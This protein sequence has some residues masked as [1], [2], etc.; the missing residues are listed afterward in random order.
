MMDP[1]PCV[2]YT[3][4]PLS[5]G[6]VCNY[7]SL[8]PSICGTN[9]SGNCDCMWAKDFCTRYDWTEIPIIPLNVLYN[10]SDPANP[11]G[12]NNIVPLPYGQASLGS[13]VTNTNPLIQY[14]LFV[15]PSVVTGCEV[16]RVRTQTWPSGAVPMALSNQ[17]PIWTQYGNWSGLTTNVG[18]FRTLSGFFD[19][20]T[21]SWVCPYDFDNGA[22]YLGGTWF[23]GVINYNAE[24]D[25]RG[26]PAIYA[27][28]VGREVFF[29]FF[30]F[31][32]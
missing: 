6:C 1:I 17:G 25:L 8:D 19:V 21:P 15:P 13:N 2:D 3:C 5:P 20:S 14:R 30:F 24:V 31:F 26:L 27:S 9:V 10:A 4:V 11:I 7:A 29:F 22:N 18:I 23:A 12:V 28:I 16:L 32:P